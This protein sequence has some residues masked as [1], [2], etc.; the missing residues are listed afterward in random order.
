MFKK[1]INGVMALG[2][3]SVLG[4][5]GMSLAMAA[6]GPGNGGDDDHGDIFDDDNGFRV[7]RRVEVRNDDD[8]FE[9]RIKIDR[10]LVAVAE[11]DDDGLKAEFKKEIKINHEADL[12]GLSGLASGDALDEKMEKKIEIKVEQDDDEMMI[13]WEKIFKLLGIK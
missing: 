12:M 11:D 10:D 1:I 4:L 9:Q 3:V 13:D 6:S 7:E 2:L 8:R 5:G